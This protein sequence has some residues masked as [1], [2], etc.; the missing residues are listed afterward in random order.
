MHPDIPLLDGCGESKVDLG[1][2]KPIIHPPSNLYAEVSSKPAL[3][4]G[5]LDNRQIVQIAAEACDLND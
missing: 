3:T 4:R 5:C 2:I 1:L